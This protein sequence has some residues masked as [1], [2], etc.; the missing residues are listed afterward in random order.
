MIYP[1]SKTSSISF[2]LGGIGTGSVGFAGNGRLKDWEIF[3]KPHKNSLNGLSHFA[4]RTER[5][6]K[7]VDARVLQGDLPP[8]FIWDGFGPS[9]ETMAGMPHFRNHTFKGEFPVAELSLDDPDAPARVKILAWSPFIP[10]AADDSSRPLAIFEITVE[11]TSRQACDFALVS[12]LGNAFKVPTATNTVRRARFA[13]GTSASQADLPTL[14]DLPDDTPSLAAFSEH[15]TRPATQLLLNSGGDAASLDYGELALT[16]DAPNVSFQ[17]YLYRGDFN[18]SIEAYW[19][20]VLKPGPFQNRNMPPGFVQEWNRRV[21]NGLLAAH[22]SLAPGAS[23]TT[24]FILSWHVPNRCHECDAK[25]PANHWQNYYATLHASAAETALWAL[26]NFF[27]LR[28][29]TMDFH[30]ALFSSTLPAAALEGVSRTLAV[31]RG[32]GCLRLEDGTFYAYEGCGNNNGC[33]PGSCAHVWNYAQGLAFLF[34]ELERTMRDAH[35]NHSVD[36]H[37]GAHFRLKL[38]LGQ[39][40][41]EADHRPCVDGQFG[42]VMKTYREWK[43]SGRTEWLA[44]LYPAIKRSVEYAWSHHNYDRWDP[45]RT[46]VIRGRQHNTLDIEFFGPSGWL[47]AH[48]LGALK[49]VAEMAEALDDPEFAD[50]CRA[51]FNKGKI[52]TDLHLFNGEFYFQDVDLADRS[53]LARFK[54][55]HDADARYWDAEHGQIKYQFGRRGRAIDAP[56]AQLYATLYGI[57]EIFDPAK[58]RAN[59]LSLHKHNLKRLRTVTNPWRVYGLDDERGVL[60][61]TW[62]DQESRP[63]IVAPYAPEVWTGQEWAFAAHLAFIGETEKAAEVAEAVC[64]R[65]DGAKRNP[66]S[67]IECGHNYARSLSAYAMLPAWSGFSFDMTK[68]MIGFDPKVAGDFKT[69]WSVDGAWGVF[70]RKNSACTLRILHGELKLKS[71]VISGKESIRD[72]Q[73]V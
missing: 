12:V 18:D 10:C 57:G 5:N 4:L 53:L 29:G 28:R 13:P 27:R 61:C 60:M 21:D 11:N 1:S 9:F 6:G 59:L 66:W 32:P 43:L 67:E 14:A 41:T 49:A 33:C 15:A 19:H 45:A 70:E 30:A 63:V 46:G 26:E 64:G 62:P 65:Y 39:K 48:Y 52:Y 23:E 73:I 36:E 24:R 16:T 51:I 47:N 34:P 72:I 22:F 68:G 56:L 42:E 44:T 35:Y 37:G 58:N 3:N 7:V 54:D 8:P 20:D 25:D 31:L 50:T 40:N 17:E 71:I 69:F 2:P 55:Q 38:P